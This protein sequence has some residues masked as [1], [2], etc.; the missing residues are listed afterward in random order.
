MIPIVSK[1]GGRGLGKMPICLRGSGV[2]AIG[3][4]GSGGGAIGVGGSGGGAI[5]VGFGGVIK[6][7]L[8]LQLGPS[9]PI[10]QVQAPVDGSQFPFL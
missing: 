4:G 8:G 3:V 10:K 9:N 7:T 5:G 2:G 6:V 1:G